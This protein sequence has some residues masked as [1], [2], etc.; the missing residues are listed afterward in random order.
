MNDSMWE[1][2]S[3]QQRVLLAA[4]TFGLVLFLS[5]A[6]VSYDG[7]VGPD[8]GGSFTNLCGSV[9]QTLATGLIRAIGV[10]SFGLSFFLIF[11]GY[12]FLTG[13]AIRNP[14]LKVVG[15]LLLMTTIAAGVHAISPTAGYSQSVFPLGGIGGEWLSSLLRD[16]F[17]GI[18]TFMILGLMGFSSLTLATD[19]LVFD[20]VRAT[21][22]FA[23]Q[24]L[25]GV[26][27][28]AALAGELLRQTRALGASKQGKDSAI[29]TPL[30]L[31][32]SEEGTEE[33]DLSGEE[34]D[35]GLESNEEE[36][37][38]VDEQEEEEE[39]DE[40]D[41]FEEDEEEEPAQHPEPVIRT[42]HVR[43]SPDG[44]DILKLKRAKHLEGLESY[45]LPPPS[46]LNE[47]PP[48]GGEEREAEIRAKADKLTQTLQTFGIDAHVVEISRGPTITVYEVALS[49][50]TKVRKIT[51]LPD[52][53][54]MALKAQTIRI[55]APIPG[56]DTVGIEVPNDNRETVSLKEL[57]LSEALA[58]G[59]HE[60]PLLLGRDA[61]GEPL[62]GDLT[63]MPHMLI[64]G[65]T[66]SGKSVCINSIIVS[67]LLMKYPEEVRLILVDPKVVELQ[68]FANLPHL[69]TP[70]VTDMRKAAK[71]LDW[72]VDEME[73]RYQSLGQ[74]G[75]NHIRDYNE[76]GEEKLIERLSTN[77]TPSE[78]EEVPRF[79]PYIVVIVDELADLM[80]VS[81][82]EVENSIC[83][84]AQKSRAVGIH[85]ILAT[86]RPSVDVLTG[87]IKSNMPSRLAFRVQGRTES[88]IILDQGGADRLLGNGDLL[89]LPPSGSSPIRC[90]ATFVEP[91]EIK[92]I[93]RYIKDAAKPEY[94]QELTQVRSSSATKEKGS[95]S[96][97]DPLYNDAIRMVLTDQ[98]GS[99]SM[100]QRKLSIGYTRAARLV[101][102]M[103]EDG[104]VGD[105]KG[106]KAREVLMTL[107]DWEATQSGQTAPV[108]GQ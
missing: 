102:F 59:K 62:I 67:L 36:W 99:V 25:T 71:V 65:Q 38:T 10:G 80:M 58:H 79:L 32:D 42:G 106:S 104:I 88:R 84:L 17:G 6:L 66:G 24:L 95:F 57:A 48:G 52:D 60:I 40:E 96:D 69:L 37:A 29:L 47:P 45:P 92:R 64:A 72:A 49:A 27:K 21:P 107:D 28:P 82:K 46:L 11:I 61:A 98:R 55:V 86:Q 4:T 94:S 78:I 12:S 1:G 75:V 108:E 101:D 43:P 87:L 73:Q 77:L 8:Q 91:K 18:G 13:R 34:E 85:V 35:D 39:E 9:G 90:Q 54:S 3:A 5:V 41:E 26:K 19:T 81:A 44:V 103:T 89:Y 33:P 2:K 30:E 50:G 74:A 100:L 20:M 93:V 15:A 56:K 22:A 70:V 7:L 105:F 76:L 14:A 23:R 16:L 53:I 51:A 63:K 83:R 68:Q 31:D 97:Q